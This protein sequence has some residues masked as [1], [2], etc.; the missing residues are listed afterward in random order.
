M[1]PIHSRRAITTSLVAIAAAASFAVAPLLGQG[2]WKQLF[3]GKDFTG[4]TIGGGQANGFGSAARAGGAG[5]AGGGGNRAGGGAGAAQPPAAPPSTDPAERGWSVE[6]GVLTTAPPAGGGR[7]GTLSTVDKFHDFELEL[8]YK[9]DEAP[10]VECTPKLGEKPNRAGQMAPEQN[11]SKDTACLANGGIYF[12][13][14]YQL[15][16]GRREAGEYVGVVMHRTIPGESIR[17]NVDW[18]STGDCGGKNHTYLQDCSQFP[19]IR[20][21]NDWNHLRVMFKGDRLQIWMNDKQI[22]DVEDKP[23]AGE[24]SWVEPA[25]ISFQPFGESGGFVGKIQFRNVRART[26]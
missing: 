10:N 12:R 1:K 25:P 19:E 20:K 5:G 17:G 7:G 23:M 2:A 3:N 14:G 16:L 4:W 24:E 22:T 11:M 8:D 6:N 13:S 9:L 18:L 21:K 15:N 26:L